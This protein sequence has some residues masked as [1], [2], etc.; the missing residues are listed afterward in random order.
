MNRSA[1]SSLPRVV[2]KTIAEVVVVQGT[3][4][5]SQLFLLFTD[6]TYY[7]LY[8]EAQIDGGTAVHPGDRAH[9]RKLSEVPQRIIYDTGEG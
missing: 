9:V 8:S 3:S 2:G 4:P 5:R 1:R 7:E 6:G